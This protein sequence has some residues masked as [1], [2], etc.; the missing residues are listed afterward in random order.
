MS[1]V[2]EQSMEGRNHILLPRG[3]W[4]IDEARQLDL[5]V[6][7]TM[8]GAGLTADGKTAAVTGTGGRQLTIDVRQTE[9]L[10]TAGA[11]LLVRMELAWIAGGG[12]V[13]WQCSDPARMSLINRVVCLCCSTP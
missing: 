10:D 7:D 9:A 5:V 3:N 4:V 8:S 2:I 6:Q 12:T 11:F 13:E 1:A